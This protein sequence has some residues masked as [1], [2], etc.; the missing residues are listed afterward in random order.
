M[1]LPTVWSG[2]A[3]K[4]CRNRELSWSRISGRLL[5]VCSLALVS[6]AND[7]G[8]PVQTE[9]SL[10]HTRKLLQDFWPLKV[11]LEAVRLQT[12]CKVYA[13]K[14]PR[15]ISRAHFLVRTLVP[16]LLRVFSGQVPLF[17]QTAGSYCFG[18]TSLLKTR[19][20]HAFDQVT[21]LKR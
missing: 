7:F 19:G 15:T 4:L 20:G 9:I 21:S 10:F 17:L 1:N 13:S 5:S 3:F 18:E 6:P 2:H 12:V 14:T 11:G 8:Q 16:D